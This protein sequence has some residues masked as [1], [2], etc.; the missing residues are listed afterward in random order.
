MELKDKV[1]L[2]TGGAAGIGRAAAEVCAARGARVVIADFNEAEGAAV[3][4]A[5]D[6]L[7]VPV[8]VA[9]EA[10]VK[11]LFEQIDAYF[12]RLDA[13]IAAA[14][15]LKGAYVPVEDFPLDVF[16]QVIQINLTGSFLCAK[17]AVPLMK[18]TGKGVIVLIS[19]IAATSV[20]SSVAYGSSKGGVSSLGITLA[21][22]LAPDNIRVNV[23]HP[24]G[25]KTNMKLSVIAREAELKG[26]SGEQARAEAA[27]GSEL[28]EP[29]GVGKILA[30]LVSDDADYVRGFLHTR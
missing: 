16:R 27:A 22:K 7:F 26:Q 6:G 8:D 20:S 19:S 9:D 21:G 28:G 24:G 1:V 29:E 2:I 3:A 4:R 25:I 12:G 14:G 23:V 30:W 10:S 13:L 5:I 17:H 11:R 15:V 18:R